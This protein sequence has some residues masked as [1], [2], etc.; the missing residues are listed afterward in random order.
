MNKSEFFYPAVTVDIAVLNWHENELQILLIQRGNPPFQGFWALPGGFIE[1][2][3]TLE[4]SALRELEE[5]TGFIGKNLRQIATFGDPGRD[6]RGRTITILFQM[7]LF[8][9]LPSIQGQ[10]DAKEAQWFSMK[11]LPSQLAFDHE[12]VIAKVIHDLHHQLHCPLETTTLPEA[13]QQELITYLPKA[14]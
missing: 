4:Q 13:V 8:G 7:L 5:E 10:D 1:E 6:P 3:E 11:A 9:S 14:A 2:H 12:Q